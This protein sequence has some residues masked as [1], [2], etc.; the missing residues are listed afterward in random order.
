M[1][2]DSSQASV[3]S[4]WHFYFHS[5]LLRDV[6]VNG[7]YESKIIKDDELLWNTKTRLSLI[8]NYAFTDFFQR[9]IYHLSSN[10]QSQK[11]D[12]ICRNGYL[13]ENYHGNVQSNI[14]PKLNCQY[15]VARSFANVK[16]YLLANVSYD[17]K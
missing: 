10:P 6:T 1:S 3:Y 4:L 5:S 16:N 9:L 12:K 11:Y 2:A 17:P 7:F 8:D 13:G 15:N 14:G